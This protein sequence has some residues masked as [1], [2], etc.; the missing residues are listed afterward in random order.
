[1]F[2]YLYFTGFHHEKC[3]VLS[4]LL[5]AGGTGSGNFMLTLVAF[6]VGYAWG[7]FGWDSKGKGSWKGKDSWSSAQGKGSWGGS[8]KGKGSWGGSKGSWGVG[9]DKGK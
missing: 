5:V 8:R 7:P 1:M 6:C 4:G 9:R 3:R 2:G